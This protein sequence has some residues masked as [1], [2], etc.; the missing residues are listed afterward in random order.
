[1]KQDVRFNYWILISAIFQVL[2]GAACTISGAILAIMGVASSAN[3]LKIRELEFFVNQKWIIGLQQNLFGGL[4]SKKYLFLIIG[5]IV[6]VVGAISIAVAII[7]VLYVK[8]YKVTNRQYTLMAFSLIP[9]AIAGCMEAYLILEYDV[10]R[11]N[12]YYIK[13]VRTVSFVLCGVFSVCAVL[14]LLGILFSQGKEFVS[15][16]NSK[17]AFDASKL[18]KIEQKVQPTKPLAR[19]LSKTQAAT[20]RVVDPS[21]KPYVAGNVKASNTQARST[22]ML[23]RASKAKPN[24]QQG[25]ANLAK[26][27]AGG[28][29][30][31][32]IMRPSTTQATRNTTLLSRPVQNSISPRQMGVPTSQTGRARSTHIRRCLNCGK[33]LMPNETACSVCGKSYN[34]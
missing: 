32:P 14:K 17:Y 10:L 5:A 31:K 9:L 30:A 18:S 29:P 23:T 25:T 6:A 19:S 12:L 27:N 11:M 13:N 1:M 3:L 4:I 34:K 7:E 33:T 15:N 8:R 28:Q 22:G 24:I 21:L 2:V 26:S 16:D 20:T